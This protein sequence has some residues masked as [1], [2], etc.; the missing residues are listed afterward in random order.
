MSG[1][2]VDVANASDPIA[3]MRAMLSGRSIGGTGGDLNSSPLSSGGGGGGGGGGGRGGALVG[4]G[5]GPLVPTSGGGGGRRR[6]RGALL[7]DEGARVGRRRA[8][9]RGGA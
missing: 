7:L 4:Q 3:A 8:R 2:A 5:A 6:R 1:A 9:L